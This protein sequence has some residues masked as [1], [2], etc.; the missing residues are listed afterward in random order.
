MVTAAVWCFLAAA[1]L[2]LV[3]TIFSLVAVA[4]ERSGIAVALRQDPRLPGRHI[5]VETLVG[6]ESIAVLVVGV[7]AIVLYVVFPILLR[8]G[9]GWARIVLLVV[10]AISLL[11]A[12]GDYGVSALK[13]IV[14][15]VATMLAFLTPASQWFRAAKQLRLER[16]FAR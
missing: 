7:I 3:V 9:F 11:G 14:A 2:E 13:V 8:R 12:T 6:V 15:I 5:D 1:F 16:R 4:S 10:T